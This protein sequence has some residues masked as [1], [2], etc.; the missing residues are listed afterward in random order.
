MVEAG[1]MALTD[2][3]RSSILNA[4]WCGDVHGGGRV[5]SCVYAAS[6]PGARRR[7][8]Q[9]VVARAFPSVAGVIAARHRQVCRWQRRSRIVTQKWQAALQEMRIDYATHPVL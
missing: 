2:W 4:W 7:R 8:R 3:A 6:M 5:G 1:M 9:M